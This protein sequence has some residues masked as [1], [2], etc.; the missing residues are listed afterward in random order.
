[1]IRWAGFLLAG[2]ALLWGSLGSGIAHAHR[3]DVWMGTVQ[4]SS[5]P[6]QARQTVALIQAGG[7]FRFPKDGVVFGNYEQKLPSRPR[8]YYTEYTVATPGERGRGAR[9]I[10]AGGPWLT[11]GRVVKARKFTEFWY[12]EDHYASFQRI[13]FP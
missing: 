4:L 7:P 1:M 10:I 6:P 3:H 5:L 13:E 11:D 2:L 8:G 9:R 12:S